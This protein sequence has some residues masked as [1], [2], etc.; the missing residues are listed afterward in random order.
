MLRFETLNLKGM[1]R[2]WGGEISDIAAFGEFLQILE[3]VAKKKCKQVVYVDRWYPSSQTC[4]NC[5]QGK[6]RKPS[7]PKHL[8]PSSM[9]FCAARR[10]PAP[11][12][13]S[14]VLPAAAD[15]PNTAPEPRK[16]RGRAFD[17]FIGLFGSIARRYLNHRQQVRIAAKI[18]N[19]KPKTAQPQY[20]LS[21]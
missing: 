6:L 3:W 21:S 10:I 15:A 17:V 1:Q 2:L 8:P 11:I 13:P 7:R 16:P 14:G 4:S 19:R 5:G 9:R 18:Q 20:D 12:A